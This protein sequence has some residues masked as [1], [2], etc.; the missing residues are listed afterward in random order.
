[1][2]E[3][4]TAATATLLHLVL[5]TETPDP[6]TDDLWSYRNDFL[7]QPAR[8]RA[9]LMNGFDMLCLRGYC[10]L[11][12][13]PAAKDCVTH[14]FTDLEP[15]LIALAREMT[16]AEIG[17]VSRADYGNGAA[18]HQS[19]LQALLADPACAFP[20]GEAW[21][22]AEVVELVSHVPGS[23]GHVPCMALVLLD[24]IRTGDLHGNAEFR[25]GAQF[26]ELL[27]LPRPAR[28][29]FLAT[30]RHLYEVERTWNPA[31]PAG[32][33]PIDQTTLPWTTLP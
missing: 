16:P 28:D 24:A 20:P 1:M 3:R 21:Y 7:A 32:A 6:A 18:R 12:C 9:A 8:I 23:P 13:R 14:I 30:F 25:L 31:I 10:A 22:P 2:P 4:R 27:A 5:A 15:H 11:T 26:D 17:H 19:A 29:V 33:L